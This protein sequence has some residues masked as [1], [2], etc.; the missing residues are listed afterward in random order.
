[1]Y[2]VAEVR[3]EPGLRTVYAQPIGSKKIDVHVV[4]AELLTVSNV[5]TLIMNYRCREKNSIQDGG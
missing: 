5:C 4:Y 1:M 2:A 3:H